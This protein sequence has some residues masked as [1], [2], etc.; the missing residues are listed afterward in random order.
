MKFKN[1]MTGIVLEPSS[2]LVIEQLSK[3]S[4]YEVVKESTKQ[5]TEKA[6]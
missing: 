5:K 1:K 3:S 6:E 2:K 4:A